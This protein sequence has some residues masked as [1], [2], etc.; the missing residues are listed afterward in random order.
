M[1]DDDEEES[2]KFIASHAIFVWRNCYSDCIGNC[3]LI[4]LGECFSA[5]LFRWEKAVESREKSLFAKRKTLFGN[6]SHVKT[7]TETITGREAIDPTSPATVCE[8]DQ[9]GASSAIGNHRAGFHHEFSIFWLI[10]PFPTRRAS[11]AASKGS[12]VDFA[13]DNCSSIRVSISKCHEHEL[14]NAPRLN[15][16]A[17][18][19]RHRAVKMFRV[20]GLQ[21]KTLENDRGAFFKVNRARSRRGVQCF[22]VICFVEL[23]DNQNNP[24]QIH[25]DRLKSLGWIF[26]FFFF[27]F[28]ETFFGHKNFSFVFF[29]AD[30]FRS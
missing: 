7:I 2:P 14:C 16:L 12:L 1:E 3:I 5:A 10:V 18:S 27:V 9:R 17:V 15:C 19:I 4:P 11:F 21:V 29:G 13:S 23:T 22:Y 28:L 30:H 8:W 24:K 26:E 20:N 25:D 6:F